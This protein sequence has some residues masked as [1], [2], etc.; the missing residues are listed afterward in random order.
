[1]ASKP[2]C[3]QCKKK[4]LGKHY[5]S[6]SSCKRSYDLA[7]IHSEKLYDLMD[8]ERKESW[9]CVRCR[10]NVI[11]RPKKTSTP[12]STSNKKGVPTASTS[13]QVTII[14][15]QIPDV[16]SQLSVSKNSQTQHQPFNCSMDNV[17]VR[18]YKV[19][20]QN[21]FE[22]LSDEE[23]DIS[24]LRNDTLNRSCP[25]LSVN[26]K[27]KIVGLG[28]KIAGLQEKLDFSDRY[29][30]QLLLENEDLKKQVTE[31]KR[32]IQHLKEICKYT[33]S[34]TKPN[35]TKHQSTQTSANGKDR[36]GNIKT[37]TKNPQNPEINMSMTPKSIIDQSESDSNY[38]AT[39]TNNN[40]QKGMYVL[41]GSQS[42]GLAKALLKSRQST[43]YE[44]YKVTATV[45]PDA[46]CEVILDS[47]ET[48]KASS[49][50]IIIINVGENDCNP[51][52][53]LAQLSI[54]IKMNSEAF[55]IVTEIKKSIHLNEYKLNNALELLCKN[56]DNC[57]FLRLKNLNYYDKY[58]TD[59]LCSKINFLVDSRDYSNKYLSYNKLK[60][61]INDNIKRPGNQQNRAGTNRRGTIPFYFKK[62]LDDQ[63]TE[64]K[65]TLRQKCIFEFFP[66]QSSSSKDSK[67]FRPGK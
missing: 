44:K 54:F 32:Q 29:T 3:A 28:E 46:P 7:C 14:T 2:T 67:F 55:V 20:V 57:V 56:F 37:S 15:N 22:S 13:K 39:Y 49:D 33:S 65:K 50:D 60:T 66:K 52:K 31:C 61:V 41:G 12:N 25:D 58:F 48:L 43:P 1:M 42:R 36:D 26:H 51:I 38:T 27:D 53:L 64:K 19:P 11:A 16:T 17:T 4:I 21:S 62:S 9:T 24:V 47:S 5:L 18:K 59:K 10:S 40:F 63:T 34:T 23:I 35:I 8:K 6:C 30:T 45:K